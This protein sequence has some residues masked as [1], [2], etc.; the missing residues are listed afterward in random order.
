MWLDET[1]LVLF[2]GVAVKLGL[3]IGS[4]M[5]HDSTCSSRPSASVAQTSSLISQASNLKYAVLNNRRNSS[6]TGKRNVPG[7]PITFSEVPY[8]F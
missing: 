5:L 3:L 2:R 6:V 8:K 7:E 4:N 1:R